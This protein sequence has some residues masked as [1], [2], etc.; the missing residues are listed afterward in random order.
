MRSWLED[1]LRDALTAEAEQVRPETMRPAGQATRAR[2]TVSARRSALAVP[3]MAALAVV[4]I[5]TVAAVVAGTQGTPP[6]GPATRTLGGPR[7]LLIARNDRVTVHDAR[8]GNVASRLELPPTPKGSFREPGGYLLAG[9][10]DGKTFYVAQSVKSHKTQTNSTRIFRA[11]IDEQG[12]AAELA[13]DVIPKMIGTA[14]SSLA[15]TSDGTRLAYS[16]DGKVCGRGKA[17]RFCPGAQLTVVDL[18]AGTMRTWTTNAGQIE[19]LSWAADRRTLGLVVKAEV[20]VLDTTAPGTTLAASRIIASGTEVTTATINPDGRGMLI[21]HTRPSGGGQ[22][23]RY[24]VDEYS[25]PDGRKIRTLMSRSHD[26]DSM[27]RWSLIRYDGTG[28]HLLL[29]GSV[30]PLS[31]VDDGRVT[32]LIRPGSPDA[33]GHRSEIQAAW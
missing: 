6:T 19:S 32:P 21:G 29:A 24:T 31:R 14:V 15:V 30:D 7:F 8:T 13:L 2:T 10:G 33:L 23:Q 20:R 3:L 26:G 25:V 12:R 4:I 16:L 1:Q 22:P 27:A 17:L 18:L 9:A 5:G 28:R 11:R